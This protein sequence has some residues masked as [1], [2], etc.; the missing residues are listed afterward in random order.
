[1]VLLTIG[2]GGFAAQVLVNECTVFEE[3]PSDHQ[4]LHLRQ[5]TSDERLQLGRQRVLHLGLDSAENEGSHHVV[6]SVEQATVD[7]GL[8]DGRSIGISM[9]SFT[10]NRR[11]AYFI[12][13]SC[14]PIAS[15][16][17]QREAGSKQG[18]AVCLEH[19]GVQEVQQTERLA[20]V[21]LYRSARQDQ[22]EARPNHRKASQVTGVEQQPLRYVSCLRWRQ[23]TG[24]AKLTSA[25][26]RSLRGRFL[27]SL[28]GGLPTHT[29]CGLAAL[30]TT[31]KRK[32]ICQTAAYI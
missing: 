1:M 5:W 18:R 13:C 27:D 26:Y 32:N 22:L 3:Q 19:V 11:V 12:S 28:F 6:G 23:T 15:L 30:Q 21:I 20:Q 16:G 4:P 25:S 10:G 9:G 17:G 29:L 2:R 14:G 7:S 24:Q 31:A 8:I